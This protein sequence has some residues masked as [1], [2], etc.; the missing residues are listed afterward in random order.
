MDSE[1]EAK[2]AVLAWMDKL[3]RIKKEF[4]K[5]NTLEVEGFRCGRSIEVTDNKI[6]SVEYPAMIAI[7]RYAGTEVVQMEPRLFD[8]YV[9][10]FG[11]PIK[12]VRHSIGYK[13]WVFDAMELIELE[14]E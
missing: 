6:I 8:C 14:D 1:Y 2:Q 4:L 13:D 11:N 12:K 7:I 5:N 10:A 9:G 3:I